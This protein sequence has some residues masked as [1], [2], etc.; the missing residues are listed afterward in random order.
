MALHHKYTL[1]C[2]DIR[3]ENT[4]KWMVIGLYTH[5]ISTSQLPFVLPS[6]AFFLCL[7]ADAVTQYKF[8]V[9]FRHLETGT[10]MVPELT[11]ALGVQ[12]VGPVVL[13]IKLGGIQFRAHG[14]YSVSVEIEGQDEPMMTEFLVQIAEMPPAQRMMPRQ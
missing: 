12:R 2:E 8:K 3:Q 14:S 13:P 9:Q 11:G 10:L 5:N 4:G 6:L 1:I 7:D